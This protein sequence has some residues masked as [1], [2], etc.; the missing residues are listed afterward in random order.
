M[1]ARAGRPLDLPEMLE[2]GR[3][4]IDR[5]HIRLKQILLTGARAR[6]VFGGHFPVRPGVDVIHGGQF[7]ITSSYDAF[8]NGPAPGNA[9]RTDNAPL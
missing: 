7:R 9:G 1:L 2:S 8:R 6:A 5:V 4:D 3:R